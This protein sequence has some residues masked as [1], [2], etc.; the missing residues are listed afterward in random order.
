MALADPD[1]W[2]VVDASRSVADVASAIRS[3]VADRL[4]I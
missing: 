3:I 1:H 2:A 4:R